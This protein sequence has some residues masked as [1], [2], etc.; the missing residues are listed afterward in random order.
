MKDQFL[1]FL[2]RWGLNAF[3]LWLAVKLLGTGYEDEIV[4]AGFWGF[5]LAGLIFSLVNSVFKPLAI[6]LSLPAILLT[7]GLFVLI[8]N[9]FMVYV[10]LL[11]APGISMSLVNSIVAGIILS[12]V[13]YI[14]SAVV[15]IHRSKTGVYT[16]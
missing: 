5:I 11:L 8:V 2:I 15:E 1:V 4:T 7:L 3:G 13:N 16:S 6:V 9:G 12:L 10:S 14:V